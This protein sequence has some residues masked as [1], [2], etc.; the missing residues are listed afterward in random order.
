MTIATLALLT[1][2]AANPPAY[3]LAPTPGCAPCGAPAVPQ[4]RLPGIPYFPQPCPPSA[5]P[6]PVLFS[7]VIVP[8]GTTITVHPG[9]GMAKAYAGGTTFGFRPGFGYRLELGNIP[10]KPGTTLYPLI[11]VYGSLVPRNG[12]NYWE[13]PTAIPFSADELAKAATGVMISKVIYLEDPKK[14]VPIAATPDTPHE[15]NEPT[16]AEAKK[17]AVESGRVVAVVTLGDRPPHPQELAANAIANTILL[18]GET[19]LAA[20]A[21]MPPL[22][23]AGIQLFDPVIGAKYP[24]EE[25]ITDG[26]DKD[27]KLGFNAAGKLAG[28]NPTD[29]AVEYMQGGK[30]KVATSNEVCICSPRFAIRKSAM[31]P[32]GV[33]GSLVAGAHV[34][35]TMRAA[36][37]T[38]M[39]AAGADQKLK[40]V[41]HDYA[42]RPMGTVVGVGPHSFTSLSKA[43]AVFVS[44]GT[45]VVQSSLGPDEANL[46]PNQLVIVK[47]VDPK[48]AVQVGETVTF[49]I[50]F[51]NRTHA[52]VSDLVITD[53][54]S[55]RLEFV[56]GSQ[57]SDRTTNVTTTANEAGSVNI[58]F[59]LPGQLAPGESGMISF[60]AKVR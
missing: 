3:R 13:F 38:K 54:L 55:G 29:V 28:L 42:T 36:Y 5:A 4:L 21:A 1:V 60:K 40:A 39:H 14:A 8:A 24:V 58:R 34:Q 59:E 23:W 31:M 22:A 30:K 47:S 57:S 20:P 48:G 51:A 11:E 41:G 15:F 56:P 18:P 32:G 43:V 10:G 49:T 50:T 25:C 7:K 26:S 44:Q 45:H 12:L 37:Q 46:N 53:S 35:N 52:P 16:S 19:S 33:D 2:T 6:A 27:V 9:S 17:A